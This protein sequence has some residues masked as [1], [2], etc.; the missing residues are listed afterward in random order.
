LDRRSS[1]MN[2]SVSFRSTFVPVRRSSSRVEAVAAAG[3][4]SRHCA[5]EACQ[6][7][8][9]AI[10]SRALFSA[11]D[12]GQIA[13]RKK[14]AC[15]GTSSTAAIPVADAPTTTRSMIEAE[16]PDPRS[17]RRENH[18]GR[19]LHFGMIRNAIPSP[20]AVPL[21]RVKNTRREFRTSPSNLRFDLNGARL[22]RARR[23]DVSR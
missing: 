8:S 7:K 17:P 15:S 5:R 12:G 13:L 16:R 3:E 2:A 6:E 14:L 19:A 9:A 1:T 11:A 20:V 22:R 23:S 4:T 21:P 18:R 10:G